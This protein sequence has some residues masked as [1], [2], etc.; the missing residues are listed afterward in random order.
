MKQNSIVLSIT[1]NYEQFTTVEK[2]IADYFIENKTF[3]DF[4]SKNITSQLYVSEASLSRFAQKCGYRGYR[5]FIYKY[6]EGFM[7]N[8]LDQFQPI[9]DVYNDYHL[10]LK[11]SFDMIDEKQIK[12][13]VEMMQDASYL[14][15][16][17]IGSSA[18]VAR[19]MKLRFMRLG[20]IVEYV[21][22]SDEMKVQAVLLKKDSLV[23]GLSLHAKKEEVLF[24]LKQAKQNGAKTILIT[25]NLEQSFTYVDEKI[26]VP[27]FKNLN[28]G[29]IISPQF[30][31]LI[32][33]DLFY[34][35]LVSKEEGQ[36]FIESHQKTL[37]A[38]DVEVN[39]ESH[40]VQ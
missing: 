26:T 27:I 18:L 34:R 35:L 8:T 7:E 29:N 16:C 5:E 30:P 10:L 38:L 40:Q 9:H 13:C 37:E 1:S 28:Y 36:E 32:I 24:A 3:D 25:G 21:D 2:R 33:V 22:Q 39:K 15:V 20:I 6:E 12:R 14:L 17:G 23:I 11:Q 19:E 4:S 31:L